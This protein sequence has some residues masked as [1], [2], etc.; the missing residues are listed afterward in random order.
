MTPEERAAI[1]VR[2]LD[3]RADRYLDDLVVACTNTHSVIRRDGVVEKARLLVRCHDMWR[4]TFDARRTVDDAAAVL[5][6]SSQ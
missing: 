4:E 2:A 3:E 5:G 6:E 1:L